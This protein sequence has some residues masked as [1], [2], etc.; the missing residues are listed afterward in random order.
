MLQSHPKVFSKGNLE[1]DTI[2]SENYKARNLLDFGNYLYN[3]YRNKVTWTEQ[4]QRLLYK[5]YK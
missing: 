3:I 2:I 4:I 1:T 5:E